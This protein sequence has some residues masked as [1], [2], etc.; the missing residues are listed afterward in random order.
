MFGARLLEMPMDIP[1]QWCLQANLAPWIAPV[2][3]VMGILVLLELGLTIWGWHTGRHTGAAGLAA[4][5]DHEAGMKSEGSQEA[6][7]P[8]KSQ[9]MGSNPS[10]VVVNDIMLIQ[11]P[12]NGH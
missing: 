7:Q 10:P 12:A 11:K 8:G 2:A 4:A 6:L 9:S 5:T 3:S 1:A